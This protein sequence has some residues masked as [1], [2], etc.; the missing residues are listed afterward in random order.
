[1]LACGRPELQ[2]EFHVI[3]D[4]LY[5]VVTSIRSK[6]SNEICPTSARNYAVGSLLLPKTSKNL[7]LI[8]LAMSRILDRI[9]NDSGLTEKE[10][11]IQDLVDVSYCIFFVGLL[12][13]F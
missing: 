5:T 3:R 12:V 8:V 9:Y 2:L 13:I 10:L 7:G 11:N 4:L 1:M 6:A